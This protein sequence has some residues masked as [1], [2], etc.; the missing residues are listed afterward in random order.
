MNSSDQKRLASAVAGLAATITEI[1]DA[2]MK[3]AANALA[4]RIAVRTV[5]PLLTRKQVAEYFLVSV[6]TIENWSHDGLLPYIKLSSEVRYPLADIMVLLKERNS[7]RRR[8]VF[9]PR[10]RYSSGSSS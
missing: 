6:R 1:I 2:R 4:D 10:A 3:V 7:V 8:A 9:E 5:E